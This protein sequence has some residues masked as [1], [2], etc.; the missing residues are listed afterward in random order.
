MLH[1]QRSRR[2]GNCFG[3]NLILPAL[4]GRTFTYELSVSDP[5]RSVKTHDRLQRKAQTPQTKQVR[6]LT[7]FFFLSLSLCPPKEDAT[8]FVSLF[9]SCSTSCRRFRHPSSCCERRHFANESVS[10]STVSRMRRR[11]QLLFV[12]SHGSTKTKN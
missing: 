10:D 7:F 11:S 6:T 4:S 9:P 3:Q 1:A 8:D 12:A 5:T 2:C